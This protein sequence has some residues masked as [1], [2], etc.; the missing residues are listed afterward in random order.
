MKVPC[1]GWGFMKCEFPSRAKKG[2]DVMDFLINLSRL[3][4]GEG[5]GE[6]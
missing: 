1:A 6:A 4:K 5:G 2:G 3:V